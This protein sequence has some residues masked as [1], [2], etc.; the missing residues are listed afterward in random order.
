PG[1]RGQ[2]EQA[3]DSATQASLRRPEL[4]VPQVGEKLPVVPPLRP[5]RAPVAGGLAT[6][7][8][9]G[10]QAVIDASKS[11]D[12]ELLERINEA[13]AECA[14]MA[15]A[16]MLL[17][18]FQGGRPTAEK[19]N[20]VVGKDNQGK[21]ITWAMQLGMEQHRFALACADV[22]LGKLKPEGYSLSPRYRYDP[23]TGKAERI[24]PE[25]VKQL[26]DRGRGA[27]LRET[28]EPDVVIHIK[29]APHQVQAVYDYKFPCVNTDQR[30]RWREYSEGRADGV[31]NQGDLYRD[32]LKVKPW[33]VQPHLG[34]Y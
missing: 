27:E 24:P 13:L 22:A 18:H 21:P 16:E 8:V 6:A 31:E 25:T 19:C 3:K 26:L 4:A 15:R 28:L 2:Y 11:L 7:G 30:S 29:G 12:D 5:V 9:M 34:V 23:A 20:E 32:A 33:R 10:G 17:K 14:N 1:A